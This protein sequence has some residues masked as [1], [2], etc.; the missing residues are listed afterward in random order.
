VAWGS[1]RRCY[2]TTINQSVSDDPERELE[3]LD[4]AVENMRRSL[5]AMVESYDRY[6]EGEHL[7]ILRTYRMFPD[8]RG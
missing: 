6:G 4:A 1:E 5:D 3:R 2:G 8:D 7:K